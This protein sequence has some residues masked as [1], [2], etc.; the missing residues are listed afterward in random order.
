MRR[1][2]IYGGTLLGGFVLFSIVSSIA[3]CWWTNHLGTYHFPVVTFWQYLSYRGYRRDWDVGLAIGSVSG[4][5]LP[6]AILGRV[7]WE[8]DLKYAAGRVGLRPLRDGE[9]PTYWQPSASGTQGTGAFLPISTLSEMYSGPRGIPIGEAYAVSADPVAKRGRFNPKSSKTWGRG[10]SAPLLIYDCESDATHAVVVSGSGGG[11]TASVTI[12]ALDMWHG[13]SIT[14]D[15]ACQA[16]E[17]AKGHRERMGHTVRSVRPGRGFNVLKWIDPSHDLAEMH[18]M[19]T[20]DWMCGGIGKISKDDDSLFSQSGRAMAIAILADMV[21]DPNLPRHKRT[22]REF[23]HRLVIPEDRIKRY[24]E[25]I[26]E[27]THSDLARDFS[28]RLM[29]VTQK[30]FSGMYSHTSN[31]TDWLSVRSLCDMVSD[32]GFDPAELIEGG[33]D[34]FINIDEDVLGFW[35]GIGRTVIGALLNEVFRSEETPSDRILLLFDEARF[36]GAMPVIEKVLIDG[37]K[38]GLTMI[39]MWPDIAMMKKVWG[40]TFSS[41]LASAAWSSFAAIG[42]QET[43]EYVSKMCGQ[44]GVITRSETT[45]RNGRGANGG[46]PSASRS[47]NVSEGRRNLIDPNEVRAM[48]MDEQ[49]LFPRG[50]PPGRC[51]RPFYFRRKEMLAEMSRDRFAKVAAE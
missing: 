38:H 46:W 4:L 49:I 32:D 36:L 19:T 45:S 43:A 22:P 27:E 7:A 31:A 47:I 42:D 41:F 9:K 51:G 29:G 40:D 10:G 6:A 16:Y 48:R 24:L 15:P 11:K 44:T 33:L 35:E 1:V 26:H 14:F 25:Q 28:G 39:T 12:P 21:W 23:R 18:V 30:T 2:W 34:V 8:T 5:L 37:R 50:A 17:V 3:F 13:S 20:A